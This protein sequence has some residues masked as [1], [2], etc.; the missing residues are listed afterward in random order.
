MTTDLESNPSLPRR[1]IARL[2]AAM[3]IADRRLTVDELDEAD[4]LDH[5]GLGALSPFVR[6]EIARATRMPLDVG[7]ACTALSAAGPELVDT[8]L[9]VL[10]HVA[11]SDG[12][13]NDDERRVFATI[14]RGL[15]AGPDETHGHLVSGERGDGVPP[16]APVAAHRGD[17]HVEAFRALGLAPTAGSAEVDAAFLRFVERYDPVKVAPLGAD[18][19]AL[20]VRKLAVLSDVYEIARE[21]AVR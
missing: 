1:A 21:A 10:A 12:P 11:A 16:A 17:D 18:F 5:I 14:A 8:V 20:A 2:I 3:M 7:Q 19:A 4:R 9:S 13:V 6:E 15:G